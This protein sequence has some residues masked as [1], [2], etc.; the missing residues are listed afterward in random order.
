M[1]YFKNLHTAKS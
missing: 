1:N